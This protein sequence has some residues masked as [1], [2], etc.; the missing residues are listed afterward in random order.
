MD[1]VDA[2]TALKAHPLRIGVSTRS[3][4]ELDEED[5]IFREEGVNV[6]VEYQ[7]KH[8]EEVLR[9]GAAFPII[10][11]IL[12]LNEDFE[13][14]YVEVFLMSKNSPDLS[15]RAFNSAKH[16][17]LPIKHGSFTSGKSLAPYLPA[18]QIDL[19]LSNDEE[20]VRAAIVGGTPAAMLGKRPTDLD[21]ALGDHHIAGEDAGL[22]T[23]FVA[24]G[25][26]LHVH[27]LVAVGTL[28]PGPH[29]STQGR[30]QQRGLADAG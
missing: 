24:Q 26:G 3:L 15:L 5:R 2:Q 1:L 7:R 27:G 9:E 14:P 6:Y 11:R 16:Y 4:F 19:F 30:A 10:K 12:A 8:E 23:I 20:D 21:G 29:A 17:G 22:A 28:G 25:V 13:N 18:W